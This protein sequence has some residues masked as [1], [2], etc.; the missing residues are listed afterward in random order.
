MNS[1][2]SVLALVVALAACSS[3]GEVRE[4]GFPDPARAYPAGGTY[5]NLDNLRQYATGMNKH[6]VQTLLGTPHF[7]EGL[8]GVREWNYLFN[9]RR[10][11][12]AT[13]VQCQFQVKFDHDGVAVGHAWQPESCAALL[14][15]HPHPHHRRHRLR[16]HRCGSP[17]MPCSP[18]T[19]PSFRMPAKHG[20]QRWPAPCAGRAQAWTLP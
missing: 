18:S 1:K 10:A 7:N 5:V 4:R 8:W 13:P 6:Q 20:W 2:W 15:H 9:F 3:K 19:A 14:P 12:G 16:R 11:V 17:P